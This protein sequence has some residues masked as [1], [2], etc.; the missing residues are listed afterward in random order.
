MK[1]LILL[2]GAAVI[3]LGTPASAQEPSPAPD[4]SQQPSARCQAKPQDQ[5]GK[6]KNGDASKAQPSDPGDQ[7]SD[8]SGVLKPPPTGD[9]MA[10]PP[11]AKGNTP[12]IRPGEVPQQPPAKN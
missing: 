6:S 2:C 9:T 4:R 1:F 11:P 5:T 7:L 8:C 3:S 10:A 12:I